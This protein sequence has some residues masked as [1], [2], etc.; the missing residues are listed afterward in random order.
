MDGLL[1]ME[2]L[3]KPQNC[4]NWGMGG[5]AGIWALARNNMALHGL[6]GGIFYSIGK[7]VYF[8]FSDD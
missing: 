2:D 6:E 3:E 5:C 7:P 1:Y 4:Q 8:I